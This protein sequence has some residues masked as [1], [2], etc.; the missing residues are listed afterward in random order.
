MQIPFRCT[1]E[2][3]L[4]ASAANAVWAKLES[5]NDPVSRYVMQIGAMLLF[6][7]LGFTM[8]TEGSWAKPDHVWMVAPRTLILAVLPLP[9]LLLIMALQLAVNW[10]RSTPHRSGLVQRAVPKASRGIMTVTALRGLIA[11]LFILGSIGFIIWLERRRSARFGIGAGLPVA[12]VNEVSLTQLLGLTLVP[13]GL[14]FFVLSAVSRKLKI[15]Q[16]VQ[17][18]PQLFED[19]SVEWDDEGITLSSALTHVRLKWP[20]ICKFVE[21]KDVFLVYVSHLS[22]H[23]IPKRAL[24][25]AGALEAFIV[26]LTSNVADGVLVPRPVSGFPVQPV[27]AISVNSSS[28]PP[29]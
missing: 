8:I 18:Q 29:A 28:M 10:R 11:W 25:E 17:G 23:M 9:C 7:A 12:N 6:A 2:D 5:E 13:V 4:D 22:F 15:K 16:Y 27:A 14:A 21:A 1:K 19:R 3:Y 24:I 26:M 20:G